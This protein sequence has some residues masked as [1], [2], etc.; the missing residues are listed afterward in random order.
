MNQLVHDAF[1][2]QL[3]IIN[4]FDLKGV[5]IIGTGASGSGIGILLAKLGV[6]KIILYDEDVISEHNVSNQYFRGD[7][8]GEKKVFALER[9]MY[10]MSPQ[11]F[12]P[13]ITIKDKFFSEGDTVETDIVFLCVDSLEVRESIVRQLYRDGYRKWVIDTRMAGE[14]YEIRT[15]DM[16]NNKE[17]DDYIVSTLST[18]REEPCTARSVIYTVMS[19]S[20][21]AVL[22]Y[23]K[24]VKDEIIP[25]VF[26]EDLA[27][28][29][30]PIYREYRV[31]ESPKERV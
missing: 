18:P 27:H 16:N 26:S 7:S 29:N 17:I 25:K 15:V 22:T 10:N 3:D 2:R 30:I 12:K 14:Y 11:Y 19:M 13:S 23:K 28:D 20:S 4:P 6:P 1:H 9:E 24:I 31:G 21:R 5:T 8:I